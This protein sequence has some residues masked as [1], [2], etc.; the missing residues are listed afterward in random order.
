VGVALVNAILTQN[1]NPVCSAYLI[2]RFA[3]SPALPTFISSLGPQASTELT[4]I[5]SLLSYVQTIITTEDQN[6]PTHL[7]FVF[8]ANLVLSLAR[9]DPN[10][11][12]DHFIGLF[13]QAQ[14]PRENFSGAN[15]DA[16]LSFIVSTVLILREQDECILTPEFMSKI[17]DGIFSSNGASLRSLPLAKML[18]RTPIDIVNLEST[19]FTYFGMEATGYHIAAEFLY[20]ILHISTGQFTI[21]KRLLHELA[22]TLSCGNSILMSGERLAMPLSPDTRYR[23]P[24]AILA[25]CAEMIQVCRRILLEPA[26]SALRILLTNIIRF[27]LVRDDPHFSDFDDDIYLYSVFAI[28]SN[29]ISITRVRSLL[30]DTAS[31]ATYYICDINYRENEY[32]V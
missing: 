18:M 5:K 19:C 8:S 32:L 2:D 23:S 21:L 31:N 28:L 1:Q 22:S 25:G 13:A 9:I 10:G 4:Q 14:K 12:R 30:K 17:T 15:L 6:F 3:L 7:L 26:D 27:V 16:L 24:I 29:A 20:D 11:A